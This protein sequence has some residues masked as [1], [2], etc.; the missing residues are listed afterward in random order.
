MQ[1]FKNILVV[2]DLKN[3]ND[4]LIDRVITLSQ[5]NQARVTVVTIAEEKL[6]DMRTLVAEET[7]KVDTPYIDIIETIPPDIPAPPNSYPADVPDPTDD[8]QEPLSPETDIPAKR[9]SPIVFHERIIKTEDQQLEEVVTSLRQFN[10]KASYKLLYGSPFIEIIREV[11][12]N[13]YDL[14]MIT[15]E[16]RTRVKEMFS[17]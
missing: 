17:R 7:D 9:K 8:I 4:A 14:V 16:S 1:R 2:L 3:K 11:L 15:A 13:K 5:R 12:K 6:R 10:I